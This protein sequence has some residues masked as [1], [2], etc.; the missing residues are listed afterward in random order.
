VLVG[1]SGTGKSTLAKVIAKMRGVEPLSSASTF[2][3]IRNVL[4]NTR[5]KGDTK[6]FSDDESF[7]ANTILVWEDIDIRVL[8]EKPDIYRMLK[9]GYDRATHIINISSQKPGENI[10][11]E[12]F[13]GKVLSTIQPLWAF[14][15]YSE[16]ERRIVLIPFRKHE[17]LPREIEDID[18]YN[19]AELAFYYEAYW[20]N[21][22]R[23]ELYVNTRKSLARRKPSD[24]TALEWTI[25]VDLLTTGIVCGIWQSTKD[26][27]EWAKRYLK[28]SNEIKANQSSP[29]L[30]L[31][32][33]YIEQEEILHERLKKNLDSRLIISPEHLKETYTRWHRQGKI[34]ISPMPQNVVEYMNRLGYSL[35]PKGWEK[36]HE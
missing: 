21:E 3:A 25:L 31:L 16:L 7:E 5:Y 29:F 24:I 26:A 2:A 11:F 23:C 14:P 28:A 19:F 9:T 32:K 18:L 4:T 6:R 22:Q 33:D 17:Q 30:E 20:A 34:E 12:T 10:R 13:C 27:I 8:E 35:T 15:K 1:Q 36:I